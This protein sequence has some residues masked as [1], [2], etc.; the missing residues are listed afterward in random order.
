MALARLLILIRKLLHSGYPARSYIYKSVQ[1]KNR[2][3]FHFSDFFIVGAPYNYRSYMYY[4]R[5]VKLFSDI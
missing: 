3:S 4:N 5:Y 2:G 1:Y